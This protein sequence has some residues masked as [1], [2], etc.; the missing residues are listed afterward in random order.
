MIRG[1]VLAAGL[2]RRMGAPKALLTLDGRT[3]LQRAVDA[4]R[5]AGLEVIAVV[6]PPVDAATPA[7]GFGAG[8][9]VNLDPDGANG[10]FGSA[11][12]GVLEALRLGDRGALLLP[13]DLPLVTTADVEAV[14]IRLRAGAEVV[15][16]THG[17]R[18]G[19]PIGIGRA[20]MDEIANAPPGA[21]LRDIV[22]REP[23]RV[24]EVAGSEGTILGVNTTED[25]ARASNRTFR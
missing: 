12:L 7:E 21:T 17:G 10:M 9:V 1:I 5:S 2:G 3:F 11:R 16:P 8:R 22:R 15:V 6:N 23:G 18:R 20:V 14:R 13:V 25:L 19:H 4:L 24:V